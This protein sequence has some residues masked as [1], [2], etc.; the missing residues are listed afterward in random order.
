MNID[1][2]RIRF[3]I[4]ELE[5]RAKTI[6]FVY[7]GLFSVFAY[8]LSYVTLNADA[9]LLDRICL[10]L[11]GVGIGSSIASM[12]KVDL[13]VHRLILQ[14]LLEVEEQP[15]TQPETRPAPAPATID[16]TQP[17]SNLVNDAVAK[18]KIPAEPKLPDIPSIGVPA[19]VNE[20]LKVGK[21]RGKPTRLPPRRKPKTA[22]PAQA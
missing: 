22:P 8:G 2:S 9:T 7:A 17:N 15:S 20:A 10:A 19:E 18:V 3:L 4:T 12:R 5:Y 14:G 13:E 11:V 21:T 1:R 6:T 16:Q